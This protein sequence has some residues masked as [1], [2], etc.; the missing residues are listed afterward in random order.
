[1]EAPARSPAGPAGARGGPAGQGKSG[2]EARAGA[3]VRAG[4]GF[5]TPCYCEENALLLG[6]ELVRRGVAREQ[7]LQVVFISNPAKAVPIWQQRAGHEEEDGLMVWDYHVI[8]LQVAPGEVRVWDFDTL[9]AFPCSLIEYTRRAFCPET[10]LHPEF[11]RRFRA[12]PLP[13]YGQFFASDRSH[14]VKE[15]GSWSAPPPEHPCFVGDGGCKTNLEVYTDMVGESPARYGRVYEQEEFLLAFLQ[16][17][18][19]Q[20]K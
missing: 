5:Y 17:M 19:K 20:A 12:V 8:V 15:D 6:R 2:G 13:L 11:M 18:G 10:A 14:M 1:M 4:C 9:L 3:E 7:D 16:M